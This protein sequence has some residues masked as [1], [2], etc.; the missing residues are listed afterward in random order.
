MTDE[1]V[2]Q[3]LFA[4]SVTHLL[5]TNG[6]NLYHPNF[7]KDL[8]ALDA[9]VATCDFTH[10][11]LYKEVVLE[12]SHIDLGGTLYKADAIDEYA[13][14]NA[15]PFFTA[16]GDFPSPRDYHDADFMLSNYIVQSGGSFEKTENILFYHQ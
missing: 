7:F 12:E 14:S 8:I 13:S 1:A 5:V 16:L 4:G 2:Q 3:Y 9:D 10:E 11:M 15:G 6:D